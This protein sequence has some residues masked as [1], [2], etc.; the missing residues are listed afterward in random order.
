MLVL[1][2]PA[3]LCR[4]RQLRS[5]ARSHLYMKI[6]GPA[7]TATP[8]KPV[9]LSLSPRPWKAQRPAGS[10]KRACSAKMLVPWYTL[11]FR[12]VG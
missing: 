5:P 2:K 11:G 10:S 12:E 4:S 9:L 8:G 3:L 1:S 7:A 6:Y